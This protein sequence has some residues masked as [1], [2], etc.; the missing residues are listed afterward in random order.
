MPSL[1]ARPAAVTGVLLRVRGLR[2]GVALAADP[3]GDLMELQLIEAE[4]HLSPRGNAPP[5]VLPLEA[6]DG[7]GV[8]GTECAIFMRGGD[9]IEVVGEGAAPTASLLARA[10][11]APPELLRAARAP[12]ATDAATRE[13]W[14]AATAAIVAASEALRAGTDLRERVRSTTTTVRNGVDGLPRAVVGASIDTPLHRARL[15]RLED[16]LRPVQ[17]QVHRLE[18]QADAVLAAPADALCLAWRPWV[19]TLTRL[20][21]MLREQLPAMAEAAVLDEP[22]A[23]GWRALLT[24]LTGRR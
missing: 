21:T 4:L 5:I 20:A 7:V 12:L 22:A 3:G 9:V 16:A 23:V 15:A 10:L 18:Q 1:A 19:G 2:N 17:Q 8:R 11:F 6:I 24:R 13:C 14:R